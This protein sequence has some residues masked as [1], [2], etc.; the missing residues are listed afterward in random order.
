MPKQTL[1][2]HLKDFL[3]GKEVAID[4]SKV[5]KKIS[6]VDSMKA[7]DRTF[8]CLWFV[9]GGYSIVDM[10]STIV[11]ANPIKSKELQEDGK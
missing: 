3:I 11:I 5:F 8:Y 4:R 1:E 2:Q 9:N 7:N 6:R 10:D